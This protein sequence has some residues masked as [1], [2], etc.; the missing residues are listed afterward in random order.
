MN[1][2]SKSVARAV[3]WA[4]TSLQHFGGI[5]LVLMAILVWSVAGLWIVWLMILATGGLLADTAQH[6]RRLRALHHAVRQAERRH[7]AAVRHAEAELSRR[8][9]AYDKAVAGAQANLA[10]LRNPNGRR[11]E[12][13]RGVTLYE[14]TIATPQGTVPLIGVKAY[15]DTAGN[16]AVT[17][18]ATL[19]RTGAGLLVAGPVGA[20]VGGAGFKKTKKIDT[21]ELYLHIDSPQLSCVVEC[22]PD[23]GAR[24]RTFA[25][26]V[27]TAASRA[28]IE[29]PR[30]PQ[31]IQAAESALASAQA[32]TQPIEAARDE[33]TE[34]RGDPEL[35]AGIETARRELE[36]YTGPTSPELGP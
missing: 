31:R 13:V 21:R 19:T 29:E 11:L 27:N 23:Q 3:E 22:P 18:R 15:V 1:R 25:A 30:R 16:M 28:A 2:Y 26:A 9:R 20:V 10:A 5:V 4:R 35:L 6:G 12:K 34:V 36:A 17:K 8:Q 7:S 32:A 14:R 24:I 33:V